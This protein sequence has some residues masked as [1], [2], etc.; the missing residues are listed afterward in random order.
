M[1]G[2]PARAKVTQAEET[3]AFGIPS[4]SPT[5]AACLE[6]AASAVYPSSRLPGYQRAHADTSIKPAACVFY[7]C[8][9]SSCQAASAF[10][11]LIEYRA[12]ATH[13]P[14]AGARGSS[15]GEVTLRARGAIFVA[16]V[17][18]ISR[19]LPLYCSSADKRLYC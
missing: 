3:S 18:T 15:A 16:D 17:C 7:F 1:G 13:A 14:E 11:G 5:E 6:E 2:I 19:I 9:W 4:S 10:S 12:K 8:I